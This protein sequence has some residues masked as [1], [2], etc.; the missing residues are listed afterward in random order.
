MSSYCCRASWQRGCGGERRH[1]GFQK[2]WKISLMWGC[3]YKKSYIL[4]SVFIFRSFSS[5]GILNMSCIFVRKFLCI[6]AEASGIYA[7]SALFQS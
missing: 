6:K 7:L 1:Q 2:I 5:I 3:V 4:N